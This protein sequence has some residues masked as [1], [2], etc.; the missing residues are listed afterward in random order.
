MK[1]FKVYELATSRPVPA[2]CRRDFYRLYLL[3]GPRRLHRADQQLSLDDGPCLCVGNPY[4][5]EFGPAAGQYTGYACLFTEAFVQENG[6][7]GGLAQWARLHG[8]AA[9]FLL[10]AEQAAHFTRLFERML[11]TQDSAYQFKKEHLQTC[12]QLLQHEV[13]RYRP[14]VPRR[15]RAYYRSPT[16]GL[17]GAWRSRG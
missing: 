17:H 12:L 15:F 10:Q 11:A 16:G 6:C 5:V 13:L 14:P 3:S 1:G 9:V 4:P 7:F 2:T 8:Q